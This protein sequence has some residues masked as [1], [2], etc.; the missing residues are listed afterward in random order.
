[1]G[2]RYGCVLG[3]WPVYGASMPLRPAVASIFQELSRQYE[4]EVPTMYL[5]CKGLVTVGVGNLVDPVSE[6]CRLPFVRAD[7]T[8]ATQAEI[9]A[10]WRTLKCKPELARQG[11]RV[12]AAWCKLH[13]TEEGIG[14]LVQA[15][16]AANWAFM[17]KTYPA[18]K[19]ADQWPAAAQLAAS[20]MAWAVGAGF[21]GIFKNW[22]ACAAK[23]DWNGC[24]ETSTINATGNPGVIPRNKAVA[25]LFRLAAIQ[26][27]EDY[28]KLVVSAELA[29]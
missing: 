22:S 8:P 29:S 27:L 16:L 20:L 21:P 26:P 3:H 4:G 24:A 25:A 2:S 11:Y 19:N 6:A 18:F 12:A 17:V 7:G 14:T 28:D 10:E 15:K 23:A 13:L 1:M 5:D 9:A